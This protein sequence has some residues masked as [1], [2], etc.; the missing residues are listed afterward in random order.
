MIHL[1]RR[2]TKAAEESAKAAQRIA[3]A[4]EKKGKL[5]LDHLFAPENAD[6]LEPTTRD[7]TEPPKPKQP[8][9]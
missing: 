5:L 1:N 6:L 2:S 4:E 7:K 9:R 8:R 3:V